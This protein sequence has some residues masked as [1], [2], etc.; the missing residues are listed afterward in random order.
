MGEL[1]VSAK[2]KAYLERLFD[3][4][5]VV[6]VL[7]DRSAVDAT[8]GRPRKSLTRSH[9]SMIT[10]RYVT[11]EKERLAADLHRSRG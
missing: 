2:T 6:K 11:S 8:H 5:E 9:E 7:I 1:T 4:E 10:N 3:C